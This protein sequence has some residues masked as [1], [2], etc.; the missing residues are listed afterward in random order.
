MVLSQINSCLRHYGKERRGKKKKKKQHRKHDRSCS[1]QSK[2]IITLE[3]HHIW[4]VSSRINSCLRHH[5][6]K[7]NMIDHVSSMQIFHQND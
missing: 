6:K 4:M 7:K 1:L 2:F 3:V 5:V